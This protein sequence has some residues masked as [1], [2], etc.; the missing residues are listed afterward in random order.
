M[1]TSSKP[2]LIRAL[3]EWMADNA[4]TPY[5][6]V[7]ADKPNCMVPRE[8]VKNGEIVLDISMTATKGLMLGNEVIEFKARFSGKITD[9]YI[10]IYA[11]SAIYAQ[12]NGQGMSFPEEEDL[13]P[14]SQEA[15]PQKGRPNLKIVD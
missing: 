9:I 1:T 15:P 8:F 2:Y 14:P 5:V 11:V 13:P 10:P 7:K 3:Y 4:L 12:E 6:L